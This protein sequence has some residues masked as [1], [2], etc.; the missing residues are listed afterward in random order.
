MRI[1]NMVHAIVR[2]VVDMRHEPP[3]SIDRAIQVDIRP[4]RK[5]E[6]TMVLG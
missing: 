6:F 4:I 5:T 3:V 2:R 1:A